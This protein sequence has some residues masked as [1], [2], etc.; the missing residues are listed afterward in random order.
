MPGNPCS[1]VVFYSIHAAVG[2]RVRTESTKLRWTVCPPKIIV[3][4]IWVR[5]EDLGPEARHGR[6]NMLEF[7]TYPGARVPTV[8]R[9]LT[10]RHSFTEPISLKVGDSET[11][12]LTHDISRGGV[13]FYSTK[14]FVGQDVSLGFPTMFGSAVDTAAQVVWSRQCSE[15]WYL[16]GA[17]LTTSTS[18]EWV[19]LRIAA[20]ASELNLRRDARRR[21]FVP[22]SI[23]YPSSPDW[24]LAHSR[25]ISTHGIGLFHTHVPPDKFAIISFEHGGVENQFRIKLSWVEQRGEEFY[26]SGWTLDRSRLFLQGIHPPSA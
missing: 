16:N 26:M 23:K 6:S 15:D 4:Y 8:Q 24:A 9:R 10:P 1:S 19:K 25:D 11:T 3:A 7:Q 12:V 20:A 13:G 2:W 14:S 18:L 17:R 22:V 5:A 21:L